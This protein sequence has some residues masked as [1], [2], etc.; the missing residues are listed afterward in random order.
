MSEDLKSIIAEAEKGDEIALLNLA[1]TYFSGEV[2]GQPDIT[3]GLECMEKAAKQGNPKV[4]SQCADFYKEL[5]LYDF[6]FKWYMEAALNGHAE[7][8][9]TIAGFYYTGITGEKD[10]KKAFLWANRAYENGEEAHA[11]A[12]LGAMYIEGQVTK[13]D[14]IKGYKMLK[15]G[16]SNG[17][18]AAIEY[19]KMI[20]NQIPQ[21]KNL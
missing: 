8:Q 17:I 15:L 6:A 16:A 19:K 21:L 10:E 1:S 2:N 3:N 5:G 11:P 20:E 4:Q 7:S 13:Q 12:L 9:A 14:I 18:E